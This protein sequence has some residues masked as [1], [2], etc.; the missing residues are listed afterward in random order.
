MVR[1][2]PVQYNDSTRLL[3]EKMQRVWSMWVANRQQVLSPEAKEGIQEDWKNDRIRLILP[4][5]DW[6]YLTGIYLV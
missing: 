2:F 3:H 4:L 1:T 6:N 5:E